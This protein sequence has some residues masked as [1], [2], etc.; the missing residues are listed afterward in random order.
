VRYCAEHADILFAVFDDVESAA[1]LA[2]S[3]RDLA[4]GEFGREVQILTSSL[5]VCR[6][7]EKE[8]REAFHYYAVEKGDFEA[9]ANYQ[10]RNP[11]FPYATA[12]ERQRRRE[13]LIAGA[14]YR[15]VGSPE[16]IVDQ[17]LQ[18][19]RAGLNGTSLCFFDYEEGMTTFTQEVMP[20]LVQAGL[21]QEFRPA[22]TNQRQASA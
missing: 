3:F 1:R 12:E 4:R 15:L 10:N 13:Q 7:T 5:V 17:C 21:R 8:A 6:P 18:L 16:Q 22:K 11:H 9:A 20:L 2:R 14:S 19:T